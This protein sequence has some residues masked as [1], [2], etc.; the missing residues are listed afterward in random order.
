MNFWH[1]LLRLDRRIVFL[2]VAAAVVAPL[3]VPLNLPIE[4]S[5]HARNLYTAIDKIQG[6]GKPILISVDYD[7][8]TVPELQP[9]TIAVLR[10]CFRKGIPVIMVNMYPTSS[11]L[12]RDAVETVAREFSHSSYGKDYVYM[13]YKPGLGLVMLGIGEDFHGTFPTDGFGK[14]TSELQIVKNVRNY[15]DIAMM[16]DFTGSAVYESWIMF[17]YQKYGC[18]VGAGVT[19]VMASDAYPFLSTGQLVGLLGGLSGAAEYE[20]LIDAPGDATVGMDA[21]SIVHILIIVLIVLGNIAYFATRR[22]KQ[23]GQPAGRQEAG[24]A[25][26]DAG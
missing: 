17:A 22:Q 19:A 12:A 15:D 18:K 2:L 3:I 14:P 6:G 9:M 20:K 11:G 4:I 10:H 8:S 16:V 23:A 26:H 7:P 25:Q 21:Q 13:G 5:Q 1:F 24:G